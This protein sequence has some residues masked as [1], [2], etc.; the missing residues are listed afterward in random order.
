MVRVVS[1]VLCAIMCNKETCVKQKQQKK[2]SMEVESKINT[3]SDGRTSAR[4][5]TAIIVTGTL[6]ETVKIYA[7][8]DVKQ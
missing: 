1:G 4:T 8:L 6:K 7:L 3:S 5:D 2:R